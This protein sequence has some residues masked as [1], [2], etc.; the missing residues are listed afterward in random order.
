MRLYH[1]QGSQTG[2]DH[3]GRGLNRR[4]YRRVGSA[5]A[6]SSKRIDQRAR[7][8]VHQHPIAALPLQKRASD[9]S[10]G[11][12]PTCGVEP[13]G[14]GNDPAIVPVDEAPPN[15]NHASCQK[16]CQEGARVEAPPQQEERLL[17]HQSQ[18][19]EIL[20]RGRQSWTASL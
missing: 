20:S 2:F 7:S 18:Q 1:L 13:T 8:L 9:H 16:S 4:C 11:A 12:I 3:S 17:P 5:S 15:G 10:H 14:R 19:P 6:S